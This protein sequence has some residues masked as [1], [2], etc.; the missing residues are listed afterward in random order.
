VRRKRRVSLWDKTIRVSLLVDTAQLEQIKHGLE[1]RT[2]CL[3]GQMQSELRYMITSE[4]YRRRKDKNKKPTDEEEAKLDQALVTLEKF[5]YPDRTEDTPR[6][7]LSDKS[8]SEDARICHDIYQTIMEWSFNHQALR[9]S[10][11]HSLPRVR[12]HEMT[13]E[14]EIESMRDALV[15]MGEGVPSEYTKAPEE[16]RTAVLE[17]AKVLTKCLRKKSKTPA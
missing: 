14:F 9:V 3:I 15:R 2:E 5:I 4:A 13:W 16:V 12:H 7:P 11:E 17:A 6:P 8:V 1:L 10:K